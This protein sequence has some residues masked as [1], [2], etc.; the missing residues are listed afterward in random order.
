MV[1]GLWHQ[2]A[3]DFR[4]TSQISVLTTSDKPIHAAPY[5]AP[6][7][8]RDSSMDQSHPSS[9]TRRPQRA[10][11]VLN[12]SG[13]AIGALTILGYGLLGLLPVTVAMAYFVVGALVNGGLYVWFQGLPDEAVR[14]KRYPTFV[15]LLLNVAVQLGFAVWQPQIAFIAMLILIGIVPMEVLRFRRRQIVLL[16]ALIATMTLIALLLS[17]GQWSIPADGWAQ[18]MLLWLAFTEALA[19]SFVMQL[20][21]ERYSR[22]LMQQ[23]EQIQHEFK[24]VRTI[25][26]RDDLTGLA[27]RRAF[28]QQLNA[29]LNKHPDRALAV[30]MI[31]LDRFKVINDRLGHA[32]GDQLL[33]AVGQRLRGVLRQSDV[34]ARLGGDEFVVMFTHYTS[35]DQLRLVADRLV[36][37]M[38][39]EFVVQGHAMQLGLSLGIVIQQQTQPV[40]ALT[41]MRRADLAMYAAKEGGRQQLRIFDQHMEDALQE[42]DRQLHWVLDALRDNRL[43]LHYQPILSF[44]PKA[45]ASGVG[46]YGAEALLRLRD[47]DGVHN[48]G[49]FEAVLD[50]EQIGVPVGRFVVSAALEQAQRWHVEGHNIQVSINISPRHFLDPQFLSELRTALE[51]HPQCPPE[52]LVLEVTEHG[53]ELDSRMAGFVV[54]R[55]RSLGVRVALDDF[56]TGSA[57]LTHLQKLEVSSV[58]IDRSFTRD[59]FT[60]GA[61]LSITYGLLRTAALMGL[62]VVAEGVSTPQHALALAAMSCRRFQGYAIAR[63]MTADAMGAWLARWREHLPWA[64]VLPRQAEISPDAIH[65]LVQHNNTALHA[66]RGTINAE[67]RAQLIKAD[68]QQHCALGLW[69]HDNAARYSNRPGFLRLM[70]EH[71]VFHTRLRE[72]LVATQADTE[73]VANNALGE[74]SRIIRHQ[75]W[76]LILL[77]VGTS[78]DQSATD[79]FP[80]ITD[81]AFDPAPAE[82]GGFLPGDSG[83]SLVR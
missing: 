5:R 8:H 61:G 3:H 78:A 63:P 44:D 54:N 70:R 33:I 53:S 49:E 50:D 55:C 74:Q 14:A 73:Q 83:L 40:D 58:K 65:A 2:A 60:S 7:T 81:G 42:R 13:Y 34:L 21:K 36:K 48:A 32:V 51:R 71:H 64:A 52:L 23:T 31:D 28:M 35:L 17:K 75:F 68:A 12:L 10:L 24:T 11:L 82:P 57:S 30:G 76:N 47:A 46:I 6:Q 18:Q 26:Y 62:N 77:G 4:R 15:F 20:F 1:C 56:G 59:L 41:L 67:E 16:Y 27:N 37:S 22:K 66:E 39:Q 19:F 80:H 38:E 9:K 29:V 45:G 43:E 79:A 69:C 72:N 25:A